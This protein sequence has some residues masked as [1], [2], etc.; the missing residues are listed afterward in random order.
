MQRGR[1]SHGA[2]KG[3]RTKKRSLA[4][5]AGIIGAA[6]GLAMTATVASA[7]WIT[8]A[9]FNASGSTGKAVH[10][11]G[12]GSVVG[13]LYPGYCNDVVVTLGNPSNEVPV[14]VTGIYW[15]GVTALQG[16]VKHPVSIPADVQQAI[17]AEFG[18]IAPGATA[19]ATIPNGACMSDVPN[20]AQPQTEDK[21]FVLNY[22]FVTQL[23]PGSE[24]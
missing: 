11:T 6:F 9:D 7:A 4:R 17:F 23:V 12:E 24:A 2:H 19:S 5:K 20:T 22:G 16:Y 1:S 8:G 3:A 14:R 21:D 18:E 15:D 13:D 10:L